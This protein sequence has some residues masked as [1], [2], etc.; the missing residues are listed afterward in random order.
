MTAKMFDLLRAVATP[1]NLVRTRSKLLARA[2]RRMRAELI[3]VRRLN[4]LTQAD[5]AERMGISQQ[6]VQKFERYDADPKLSTMRRYANAVGAIVEH[7]V[8]RDSGQ[9]AMLCADSQ[10]RGLG[11]LPRMDEVRVVAYRDTSAHSAAW[12]AETKRSHFALAV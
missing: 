9:S 11:Q 8:T 2:D 12:S 1:V 10:W 5:V 6:A 3:E 7:T 4:D